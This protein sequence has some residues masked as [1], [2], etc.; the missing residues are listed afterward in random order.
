M[1]HLDFWFDYS[2][3]YA[4]FGSTQ[5]EALARRMGAT[6]TLQPMLLGG[7]FKANGTPQNLMSAL[8]PAK[9]AHN[10]RDLM[11]WAVHFDLPLHIPKTHP[12]RTVEALRATIATAPSATGIDPKVMHGFFRA[13]WVEG[14][15]PS[16][17]ATLRDVLSAA[18]HEVDAV[19]A[20]IETPAL[21]DDLR[22]RTDRAIALGVF[23]APSYLV[24]GERLY[25][26]QDRMHFV[27]GDRFSPR[28]EALPPERTHE[29]DLYWDFSSPFAYFA[30]T[31]AEALA[32]RTKA[33]LTWK[34]M[35]LGGLFRTIGQVDVP[36]HAMSAAKQR[37]MRADMER[38]AAYYGVPFRFPTRFP[39]NTV[40]ALRVWLALPEAR[41]DAFRAATF[42]AFWGEDRDI[43]SDDVLHSL[44]GDDG[45]DVLARTQSPEIKR[46]LVEATQQ[47]ADAGVFGAPTFVVDGKDLF[48][49]QDRMDFVERALGR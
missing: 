10:E 39:M 36:L 41:R 5:V 31:Q 20:R 8:S 38:W 33:K 14:R 27:A 25:W 15:S 18:G 30:S 12:M 48:W 28:A 6:L 40:K 26:G 47:A 42:R 23:G 35:L 17:P 43:A 32:A 2:C 22:A 44:I 29:L 1:P 11:R 16:D 19:L 3:P 9:A 13:Y 46:A 37:M 49:G 4:Y 24:D 21:K 45:G 7:V 34:P